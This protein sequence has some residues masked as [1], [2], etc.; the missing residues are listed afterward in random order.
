MTASRR[1]IELQVTILATPAAIWK[2][3]SSGEGL[4]QW[5][6]PIAEGGGAPGADVLLSWGEGMEWTSQNTAWDENRHLQWSDPPRPDASAPGEMIQ[7]A[8]DW[9]IETASGGRCV[10]RLVHSGFGTDAEWDDQYNSTTEG[11]MYFL[12]NL[13]HYLE[14]HD[15]TQR[16]AIFERRHATVPHA[17]IWSRLLGD[18]G[19]RA[20]HAGMKGVREGDRL[21]LTTDDGRSIPFVV[22]RVRPNILWGTL[23]SLNDGLLLIEL[24]TGDDYHYGIYMSLYGVPSRDIESLRKWVAAVADSSVATESS[25]P[26]PS[27]AATP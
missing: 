10:V 4:R 3:L 2:A 21:V 13:R 20:T 14:H 1:S 8:I 27:P 19:L 26:A 12:F 24:E 6:P 15:G 22:G 17:A 23:D 16:Q 18:D 25:A 9:Y 11:W 5:F 7:M